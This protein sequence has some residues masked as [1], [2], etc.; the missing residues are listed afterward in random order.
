LSA[1]ITESEAQLRV[2][3]ESDEY[4]KQRQ[5]VEASEQQVSQNLEKL[6][7]TIKDKRK[8][9]MRLNTEFAHAQ[10]ARVN[11]ASDEDNSRDSSKDAVE[12]VVED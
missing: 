10:A 2:L 12:N 6:E 1:I 8:E 11:N 4:R 7:A 5:L 9:L 3:L